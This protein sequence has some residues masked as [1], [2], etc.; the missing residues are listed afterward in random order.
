[1]IRK[2]VNNININYAEQKSSNNVSSINNNVE[3]QNVS[4][5]YYNVNPYEVEVV[6]FSLEDNYEMLK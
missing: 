2:N 4:N 1:M 5:S 3:N 6:D